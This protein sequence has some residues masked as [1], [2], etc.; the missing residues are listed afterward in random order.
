MNEFTKEELLDIYEVFD[1]QG[2]CRLLEL[3]AKIKYMIDNY[4]EHENIYC[5]CVGQWIC[6]DCALS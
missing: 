2:A 3:K 1:M 6:D 5:K 4:C